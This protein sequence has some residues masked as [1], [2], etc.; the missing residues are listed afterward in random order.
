MPVYQCIYVCL[1]LSVYVNV[2]MCVYVCVSMRD[3]VCQCVC[4]LHGMYLCGVC[5][6]L[7]VH[8]HVYMYVCGTQT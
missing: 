8:V 5:F 4:V 3:Y 2:S 7:S 6:W 1:H